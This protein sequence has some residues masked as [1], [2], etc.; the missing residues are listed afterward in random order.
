MRASGSAPKEPI[1]AA[2]AGTAHPARVAHV[3]ARHRELTVQRRHAGAG[4]SN[5]GADRAA[6]AAATAFHVTLGPVFHGQID[7]KADRGR[8]RAGYLAVF[9]LIRVDLGGRFDGDRGAYRLLQF[10]LGK[11]GA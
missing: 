6:H 4:I 7:L 5:T 10:N 8:D 2:G 11:L 9:P 1:A 3:V